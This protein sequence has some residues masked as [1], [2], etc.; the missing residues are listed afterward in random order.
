MYLALMAVCASCADESVV[1]LPVPD[2]PSDVAEQEYYRQFDVLKSY[3]DKAG[4][5]LTTSLSPS[6]FTA[7]QLK[8]SMVL[9]NFHGID[10]YGSYM[11]ASM[12]AS[13][14]SY[15]FSSLKTVGNLC[16]E[17][18]LT[19]YGVT[20]CSRQNQPA[21]YLNKLLEPVYTYIEGTKGKTLIEDFESD[22]LGKQYPMTGGSQAVI[23]EDPE[24]KKGKSL[25]CGTSENKC[26]YS[27]PIIHIKLPEGTTLGDYNGVQFDHHGVN[28]DGKFGSG[29]RV[30][31]NDQEFN[32]GQGP[33]GL[34]CPDNDWFSAT[35]PFVRGEGAKSGD[36]KVAI[37]AEL[38]GLTEFDL[39]L[40]SGSGGWQAYLDNICFTW[41]KEGETLVDE[42]TPEQKTEIITAELR[43]W[44][45]GA[46]SAGAPNVTA[47]T[48]IDNPL[49]Q[50]ENDQTFDWGIYL[51]E[52]KYVAAAASIAREASE[53]SLTFLVGQNLNQ[54]DDMAAAV[55][56]LESLVAKWNSEGAAIDGYDIRI[57]AVCSDNEA[58]ASANLKNITDA[59]NAL[60]KT[61]KAVRLSGVILTM[62]DN[63]GNIL[64]GV[65]ITKEQRA[66]AASFL[67]SV[68][69]S[70]RTLVDADKQLGFS[71]GGMTDNG[72]LLG[73]WSTDCERTSIYEGIVN[74]IKN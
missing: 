51:G 30:K 12:I 9:N 13:D 57:N 50:I 34:G 72:T 22:E 56:A 52:D 44:I 69:T 10:V 68:I 35:I 65:N 64:T 45:E 73:P 53:A 41:E 14:G 55:T 62:T 15:D 21:A 31:I 4:F 49:D 74:A 6:D 27:Y 71:I 16:D 59:I 3:A 42:K 48:L 63:D 2:K 7:K 18:G 58:V 43:K 32:C 1:S 61:G 46:I 25:H 33:V 37:P 17:N 24:G 66:K 23:E 38:D 28:G 19:L 8:Y 54:N 60:V 67:T 70:Y 29:F 36:G 39:A 26:A 20:L 5:K 40:G 47:W 11:P